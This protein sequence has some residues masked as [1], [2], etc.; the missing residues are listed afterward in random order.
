MLKLIN[1]IILILFHFLKTLKKYLIYN[2]ILIIEVIKYKY[3][4]N[5]LLHK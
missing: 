1:Y 4:N 5:T 3:I 2:S